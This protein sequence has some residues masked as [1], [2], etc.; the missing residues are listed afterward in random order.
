[1]DWDLHKS[2]LARARLL[3]AKR[4]LLAH[5]TWLRYNAD[6]WHVLLAKGSWPKDAAALIASSKRIA[7]ESMP[8]DIVTLKAA[9]AEIVGLVN[10]LKRLRDSAVERAPSPQKPS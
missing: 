4:D 6:E 8:M 9:T 2:I 10:D 1:M 3:V 7:P 5:G